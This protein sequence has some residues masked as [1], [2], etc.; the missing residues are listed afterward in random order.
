MGDV[1]AAQRDRAGRGG[2]QADQGLDQF[3]LAV[4]EH[5]GD[6]DDLSTVDREGHV[7]DDGTP[8]GRIDGQ[9]RDFEL[10]DI[11]HGRLMRLRGRQLASHHELCERARVDLVGRDGLDGLPARKTVMRS[12]LARTSSSLCEMKITV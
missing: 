12:A 1:G 4:A 2:V 5:A 6:A 10:D 7:V 11:G 9:V 8:T 3:G